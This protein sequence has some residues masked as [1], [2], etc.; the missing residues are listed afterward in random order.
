[1]IDSLLIKRI[2]NE[3]IE[4]L[5]DEMYEFEVDIEG[6]IDYGDDLNRFEVELDDYI[7]EVVSNWYIS[8]DLYLKCRIGSL[9][10]QDYHVSKERLYREHEKE[11]S[12]FKAQYERDKGIY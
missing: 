12:Y 3:C 6:Y 2:K 4:A 5:E 11:L 1:M 8:A 9:E 10:M 7:P